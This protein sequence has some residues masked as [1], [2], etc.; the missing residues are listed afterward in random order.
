[1]TEPVRWRLSPNQRLVFEDFDDG[2]V[3]FDTLVGGTHLVN[4][5]AAEALAVIEDTPGLSAAQIHAQLLARL[6]IGP[7]A[8]PIEAVDQLL[9]RLADLNFVAAA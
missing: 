1:M 2:I 7:D 9:V 6:Q 4:A 8:L 3:V 5:T